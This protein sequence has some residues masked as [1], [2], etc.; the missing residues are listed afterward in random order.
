MTDSNLILVNSRNNLASL[1]LLSFRFIVRKIHTLASQPLYV[2]RVE[3]QNNAHLLCFV[4]ARA[5]SQKL[6]C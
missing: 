2:W 4:L 5:V 1:V 6:I 3:L